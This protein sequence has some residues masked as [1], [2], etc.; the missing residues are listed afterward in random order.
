MSMP[1]IEKLGPTTLNRKWRLDVN[2]GTAAAPI[3]TPVR[4]RSD[5]Q[6]AQD[7]TL[8]EDSDF[9]SDGWKSQ[10]VTAQA[11]SLNFKVFR[12]VDASSPTAYDAGQEFLRL[13]A[14]QMGVANS[15]TVRWYE[16]TTGSG[17]RVEAYQGTATVS[18]S[19]DGGGMDGFDTV[20]VALTGQGARLSI[21][22]PYPN[23]AAAPVV[24]SL[25]PAGGGIA[26]GTLVVINGSRFT[27]VTGAASVKF[28][29]TNATDYTVVSDSRIDAVA[30]AHAAGQVDVTVTN[31][32]GTSATSA[33]SKY[34]YA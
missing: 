18:W 14:A 2:T 4:G 15:V 9:D 1:A 30:P 8:Q 20:S 16:G 19:P 24:G 3:W 22:H 13:A 28:G 7:P 33:G 23:T 11:W 27:G 32:T 34:T 12:K 10:S 21:T 29:T 17:P 5:F 25:A 6:P 26:G 31:G